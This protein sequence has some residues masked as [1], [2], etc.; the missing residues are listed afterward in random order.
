MCVILALETQK[1]LES[2]TFEQLKNAEAMNPD[3]N[4]YA[5]LK[6][7]KVT[8]EK[9]VTME[10]IWDKI[11]S[12][13]IVAPCIIHARITSVGKTLPELCH[14]F[15]VNES[16][17]NALS[18]TISDDESVLFHNGTFSEY[19]DLVLQTAMGS[20]RHLPSGAMSDTRGLAFCLQTLG[21]EALEYID[22][23]F[24]KFAVLNSKGLKKFG[25]WVNVNGISSS[26]N[27]YDTSM[28][29]FSYGNFPQNDYFIRDELND[30]DTLY[31]SK[32]ESYNP[33][34]AQKDDEDKKSKISK[35][36]HKE[37]KKFLRQHGWKTFS[38][39][40]KQELREI[41]N[42]MQQQNKI[43]KEIEHTKNQLS[44]EKMISLAK[45]KAKQ[46]EDSLTIEDYE[47]V[48]SYHKYNS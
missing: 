16:S 14:P 1:E 35:K 19:K 33:Y 6:N 31:Y 26:N 3:G 27:Y 41:V 44:D 46:F 2:L 25:S 40:S 43:V 30:D 38:Q 11:E 13:D 4:G 29:R 34:Q 18:G 10:S 48:I 12:G 28:T 15:V 7:G 17:N 45:R 20:G 32:K 8:F 47:D 39:F 36:E 21:I 22:T 37:N 23:G 24:N 42:A 5:T 9:S